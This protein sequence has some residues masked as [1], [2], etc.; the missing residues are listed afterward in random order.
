[1]P[2]ADVLVTNGGYG[3]VH[4]ALAHGV[5]IVSA[6]R[7][8]DKVDVCARAAWSGVGLDLKVHIPKPKQIKSV[9]KGVEV[10]DLIQ[11]SSLRTPLNEASAVI[12]GQRLL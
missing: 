8:E 6:G 11:V 5:P 7:T 3:G 10:P 4:F 12:A 9:W 2:K 1:L